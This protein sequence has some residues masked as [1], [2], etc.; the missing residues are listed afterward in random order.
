MSKQP[1]RDSYLR[2]Y[3]MATNAFDAEIGELIGLKR[4]LVQAYIAGR[5][6]EYL[7]DE[8]KQLLIQA[9]RDHIAYAQEQLEI[10]ELLQ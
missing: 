5:T 2:R 1:Q 8:Q 9:L 7:T 3:K 10:M 6:T 4:A